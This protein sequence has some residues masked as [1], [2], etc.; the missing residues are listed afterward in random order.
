MVRVSSR[1]DPVLDH[2]GALAGI[3]LC[4]R[5]FCGQSIVIGRGSLPACEGAF[6]RG[7]FQV[8][9]LTWPAILVAETDGPD[10]AGVIL[11]DSTETDGPPA[12]WIDMATAEAVEPGSVVLPF[13]FEMGGDAYTQATVSL[14]G[15]LILD[16]TPSPCPGSGDWS[17]FPTG[18][19]AEILRHRVVGRFPSRGLRGTGAR[20]SWKRSSNATRRSSTSVRHRIAPDAVPSLV[21]EARDS[22][23]VSPPI[24][25]TVPRISNAA[26]RSVA[27]LRS[28]TWIE[29]AW[30][31]RDAASFF[32]ESVA[33][34]V[35]N[36]DGL[37]DVP[38]GQPELDQVHVFFGAARAGV[39]DSDARGRHWTGERKPLG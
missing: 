39:E 27:H 19:T 31:G 25:T 20:L 35:V 30:W 7:S 9:A 13:A 29:Q 16:G 24:S 11:I 26:A 37:T 38:I 32:G 21:R 22:G 23:R 8:V 33:T 34:G 18:H 6:R 2:G 28:T 12:G 4:P 10:A 5:R 17:G 14:A 1:F 36:G 15:Q 3:L